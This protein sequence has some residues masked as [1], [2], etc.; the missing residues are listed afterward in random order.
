MPRGYRKCTR[1]RQV[2]RQRRQKA[3]GKHDLSANSPATWHL[4]I[5]PMSAVADLLFAELDIFF[6]GPTS[7]QSLRAKLFRFAAIFAELF[8]EYGVGSH[9]AK[10]ARAIIFGWRENYAL[11]AEC[12]GG[13]HSAK[14]RAGNKFLGRAISSPG[15]RLHRAT[16]SAKTV[17]GK[18]IFARAK[19]SP[20]LRLGRVPCLGNNGAREIIRPT[21]PKLRRDVL[22]AEC[23]TRQSLH[24]FPINRPHSHRLL[25]HLTHLLYS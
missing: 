22:F 6:A 2:R 18:K 3:L 7:R 21:A 15:G 23:P 9:S 5:G 4:T 12:V 10:K 16:I 24:F 13:K 17:R 11:F 8:A 14:G 25:T 20:R 19:S 1:R